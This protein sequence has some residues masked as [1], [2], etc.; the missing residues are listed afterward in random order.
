MHEGQGQPCA[1]GEFVIFFFLRTVLDHLD[2]ITIWPPI[3]K[4][5][6]EMK[7]SG[8]RHL[9]HQHVLVRRCILQDCPRGKLLPDK[10]VSFFFK[11]GT[12]S[13]NNS[14]HWAH[15]HTIIYQ[16]G[17]CLCASSSLRG[18]GEKRNSFQNILFPVSILVLPMM[19]VP[20]QWWHHTT[21]VPHNPGLL[22]G[23][24]FTACKN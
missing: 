1:A 5:A 14:V 13:V 4:P 22:D 20:H 12:Q 2:N 10:Q 21:V 16:D 8:D 11:N 6:D 17:R 19:S 9:C 7:L 23:F 3:R 15:F 24:P 18:L